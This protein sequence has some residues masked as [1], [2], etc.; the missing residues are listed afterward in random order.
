MSDTLKQCKDETENVRRQLV[1]S[2]QTNSQLFD[3]NILLK[4]QLS[5]ATSQQKN[6]EH[7]QKNSTD[8]SITQS[9]QI[10]FYESENNRLVKEVAELNGKLNE[11]LEMTEQSLKLTEL[12][13]LRKDQEDLLELLNDQVL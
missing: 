1:E 6:S 13:Q 12:G 11:A 8:H 4:A 5:A 7:I 10:S 2:Q 3:Q 9:T